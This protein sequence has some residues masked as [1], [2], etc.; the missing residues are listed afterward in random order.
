MSR[1]LFSCQSRLSI[2]H[3]S[4]VFPSVQCFNRVGLQRVLN[5][6]LPVV[7]SFDSP[8]P[9]SKDV[10]FV[11]NSVKVKNSVNVQRIST[12]LYIHWPVFSDISG[13]SKYSVCIKSDNLVVYDWQSIGRHNYFSADEILLTTTR[14]YTVL[15]SGTNVGGRTSDPING[16]I[17]VIN[18]V[19][20]Q[21]GKFQYQLLVH[22][23]LEIFMKQF[24]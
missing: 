20:V 17:S 6:N 15:V 10:H 7:V 24:K 21:T 9:L 5:R 1:D 12:T 14:N 18:V 4:N 22:V 16:S 8:R 3:G 13:I 19:P 11:V 2:P 23:V